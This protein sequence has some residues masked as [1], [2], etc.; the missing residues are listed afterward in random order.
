MV[1]RDQGMDETLLVT[2]MSTSLS[3]WMDKRPQ[4]PFCGLPQAWAN[5]PPRDHSGQTQ[6]R[7]SHMQEETQLLG[8][9]W[10]KDAQG[11]S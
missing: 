11:I 6:C 8:Y 9:P 5:R 4:E 3:Q 2:G 7:V 1:P 10:P